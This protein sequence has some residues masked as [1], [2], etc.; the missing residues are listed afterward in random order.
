MIRE[1]GK[2]KNRKKKEKKKK[3]KKNFECGQILGKGPER[4]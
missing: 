1:K 3:G 2:K 4:S